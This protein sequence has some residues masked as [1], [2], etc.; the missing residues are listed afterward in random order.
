MGRPQ[1]LMLLGLVA[2]IGVAAVLIRLLRAR[3][4][5]I[6]LR[7][8]VFLAVAAITGVIS[9]AF[10]VIV[11]DAF[12]ARAVVLAQ[13]AAEDDARLVAGLITRTAE[14]MGV[15][16]TDVASVLRRPPSLAAAEATG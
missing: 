6:S 1:A 11:L 3:K 15:P 2:L 13:R 4:H 5:G 14:G 10:A 7:M 9:A 16:I 12:E 8:Q